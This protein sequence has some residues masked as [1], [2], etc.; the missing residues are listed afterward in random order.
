MTRRSK[1]PADT[2][3][4]RIRRV[5][6]GYDEDPRVQARRDPGNR[7]NLLID[8]EREAALD[9]ALASTGI[10]LAQA[11]IVDVGC[12]AGEELA[13]L[14]RQGAVERRCHGID[15]L[16]DRLERARA[17]L[18]EADLREGD[19]RNLPYTVRS[20]DLVVL[21]VVMSSVLDDSVCAAIAAEADR[22][23]RPGGA[24]LWYDNRYPNP[25]NRHVRG[26]RRA[27]LARLFEGYEMRLR[28]VTVIPPL[29]RR[30]GRAT[31]RG[32]AALARMPPLLVRYA[33]V[34]IKPGGIGST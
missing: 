12:G 9:A 11:E 4:D 3:A 10:A 25:F 26:L 17:L 15:L 7:A 5:Y 1:P 13:R 23:L 8:R 14:C 32:Y 16:A 22:V 21:K 31:D 34:L 19:A 2:E 6:A 33:G 18:P 28:P 20:I 24:V 29:A 30:L 27:E